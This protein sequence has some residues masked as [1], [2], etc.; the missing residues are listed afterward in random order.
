MICILFPIINTLIIFPPTK[1]LLFLELSKYCPNFFTFTPIFCIKPTFSH[2]KRRETRLNSPR[3]YT[4]WS[5]YLFSM[6][7]YSHSTTVS[8]LYINILA[9]ANFRKASALSIIS[10]SCAFGFLIPCIAPANICIYPS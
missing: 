1:L 2:E 4:I 9:N 7:I 6:I 5:L 3:L 8:N 10:F